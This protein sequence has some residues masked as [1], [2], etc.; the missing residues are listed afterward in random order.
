[1]LHLGG[2]DESVHAR[3]KKQALD[4]NG[5][6]I[7]IPNKNIYNDSRKYEVEYADVMTETLSSNI[8]SENAINH[9]DDPNGIPMKYSHY[10]TC[11]CLR[12]PK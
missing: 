7:G 5:K 4:I 2:D 1:M 11:N 3:V 8:I 12:W 6:L 9:H 10:I